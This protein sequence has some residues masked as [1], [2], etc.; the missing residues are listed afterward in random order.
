MAG[1]SVWQANV[2]E[3]AGENDVGKADIGI[4]RLYVD[5]TIA[6]SAGAVT[7]NKAAGRVKIAAG[8]SSIVVTNDLVKVNSLVFAE[9][10]RAD[11]TAY[12]KNV[13]AVAGSFTI[14]L[15]AAATAETAVNFFVVST[16]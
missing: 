15:G 4:K 7:I 12:I 11:A 9:V 13:V 3:E 16:D 10:A 5:Y 1:V 6:A 14:T 2:S 8:Q